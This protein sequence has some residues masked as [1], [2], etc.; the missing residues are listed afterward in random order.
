MARAFP[1]GKLVQ[2]ALLPAALTAAALGVSPRRS[3]GPLVEPPVLSGAPGLAVDLAALPPALP[4]LPAGP[5]EVTVAAEL[6]DA[7]AAKGAA[8]SLRT[9]LAASARAHEADAALRRA[10]LD[11]AASAPLTPPEAEALSRRGLASPIGAGWPGASADA[12][13]GV[14]LLGR[15]VVVPGLKA[16]RGGLRPNPV[17]LLLRGPGA[18]VHLEGDPSGGAAPRVDL[19]CAAPTEAEAGRLAGLLRDYLG[20]PAGLRAR[21]PWHPAPLTPAEAKARASWSALARTALAALGEADPQ[22]LAWRFTRARTP[23]EAEEAMRAFEDDL[24]AAALEGLERRPAGEDDPVVRAA[25]KK[26]LA[27]GPL[28]DQAHG[29]VIGPTDLTGLAE[30]VGPLPKGEEAD[31]E[32]TAA[33][34]ARAAGKRVELGGLQFH[35]LARGL[36]AL[37]EWLRAARCADA[38][39]ALVDEGRLRR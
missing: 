4:A 16:D 12:D 21:P 38:R 29:V 10:L 17:A 13:R 23:E 25:W 15:L 22:Q 32:L 8:A 34:R 3:T 39:L 20:L 31:L 19:T 36:P 35:R 11:P 37:L 30:R 6:P 14:L 33:G 2:L 18:K 9:L 27:E 28:L 7:A 5:F 1:T 26:A 24:R